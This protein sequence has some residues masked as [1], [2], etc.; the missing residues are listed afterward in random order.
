[1]YL[2]GLELIDNLPASSSR[3]V[4]LKAWTIATQ[5]SFNL[6]FN[7]RQGLI[8]LP[9]LFLNSYQALDCSNPHHFKGAG[10]IGAYLEQES[11][12]G[13]ATVLFWDRVLLCALAAWESL[14]SSELLPTQWFPPTPASWMVGLKACT[15]LPSCNL[16]FKL[17]KPFHSSVK[18]W[19]FFVR[20][21]NVS[22][23]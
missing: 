14:C 6:S 21:L 3:M 4:W 16:V 15:I 1:M 17:C 9:E 13:S 2:S 22:F 18:F 11:S 5:S 23:V 7:L 19:S 8:K 20:Y 12:Y 10:T